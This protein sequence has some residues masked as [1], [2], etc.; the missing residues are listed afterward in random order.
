[1]EE[2]FF[3]LSEVIDM[4]INLYSPMVKK[5]HVDERLRQIEA[6]VNSGKLYYL[7]DDNDTRIEARI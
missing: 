1:M 7:T 5:S 3:V 4:A 2:E 6:A